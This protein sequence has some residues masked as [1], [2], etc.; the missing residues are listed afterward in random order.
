MIRAVVKWS[1]VKGASGLAK[2]KAHINYIQYREGDDRGKGPREFFN[3][4]REHVLGREIKERLDDLEQ[5]G[6]QVHKFILSPGIES[7]DIRD[8]TREMMDNLSRSKGLDLEW[9]AVEHR[10]T[11]HPH[12]HVVVMGT[13]WNGRKV[14]FDREDSKHMRE[15]GDKYLEREHQLERYLDKEIERLLK[16]PERTQE[17]EYKRARGDKDYERLMYGDE[18]DK[19]DTGDAER[20][21]REWEELDRDLHKAFKQER[22]YG[23]RTTYKQ[24]QTES[25]GRL[26]DVHEKHQEREAREYW[27]DIAANYPELAKD[28]ERQLEWLDQIAQDRPMKDK[29][30]DLD[31]LLD[32]LDPFDREMRDFIEREFEDMER[33][34]SE[35]WE[36]HELGDKTRDDIDPI[37][38]IF[39]AGTKEK[40]AEK[41]REIEQTAQPEPEQ[42]AERD[43]AWES[44]EIDR[45]TRGDMGREDEEERD[46]EDDFDRG[47]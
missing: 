23:R 3:E 47:R 17:L 19:R 29:E 18:R 40:E 38:N 10:N 27:S 21:R 30:P 22:S 1:Y 34:G 45:L 2:A 42:E 44:F 16:E 28:A 13:D 7:A 20:D 25:A 4:D 31:K 5:R 12:A 24:Y 37:R 14:E 41:E 6:V 8:Y 33:E 46:R 9:Y 39:G 43:D 35:L 32:G 36:G 26:L 15:W 11:E